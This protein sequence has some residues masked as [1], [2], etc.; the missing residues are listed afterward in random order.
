MLIG[1]GCGAERGGLAVTAELDELPHRVRG[2]LADVVG[3][4]HELSVAKPQVG[5]IGQAPRRRL[6]ADGANTPRRQIRRL[7]VTTGAPRRP[8]VVAY[9]TADAGVAARGA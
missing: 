9:R 4:A 7:Q 3:A 8:F 1:R 5:G 2:T 6:A